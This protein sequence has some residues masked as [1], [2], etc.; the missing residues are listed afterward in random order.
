MAHTL[1]LYVQIQEQLRRDIREGNF[2]SGQKLPSENELAQQYATTRATVVHAMQGL[3]MDGLIERVRGK[4]TFVKKAPI[5]SM[6]R[7]QEIGFFEKDLRNRGLSV[8]YKVLQFNECLSSPELQFQLQLTPQ[9]KIYRLMRLRYVNDKPLALEIRYI[10]GEIA[11]KL[12][13]EMLETLPLQILFEQHLSVIIH[14]I[15]NQVR[16]A[17]PGQE[18]APLLEIKRT[19]PVMVRQHTCLAENDVPILCGETW[20]REEYEFQYST[21]RENQ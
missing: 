6:V 10:K 12:H 15:H 2:K 3:L 17:L 16:V 14:T 13:L 11:R 19:R 7:K 1:P 21:H 18:I 20:Y 9:D 5:I 4:G 8:Q